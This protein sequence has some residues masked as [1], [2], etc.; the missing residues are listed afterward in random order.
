V[1]DS[2]HSHAAAGID[3][4]A[5]ELTD[6]TILT[7]MDVYPMYPLIRNG[8][9]FT[10]AYSRVG[11][12]VGYIAPELVDRGMTLK[13][14]VEKNGDLYR[15]VVVQ[16]DVQIPPDT[17][18]VSE[19]SLSFATVAGIPVTDTFCIEFTSSSM[20][21]EYGLTP[22]DPW[23]IIDV[24]HWPNMIETP[25][26]VTVLVDADQMAVGEYTGT[27][28]IILQD[29]SIPSTVEQIDVTLTVLDPTVYPAGD[30]DCNGIV[31]I[32]DLTRFIA[33]LFLGGPRL[34]YCD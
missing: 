31:D 30:F 13:W 32:G 22:S 25:T 1:L 10:L 18:L 29:P 20:P 3:G 12:G 23:I 14:S 4:T 15:P 28:D 17:L 9:S 27:V 2:A 16:Y 34:E 11:A 26:T 21:I 19:S 24:P 6:T 33:Y 5:V 8:E 7:G